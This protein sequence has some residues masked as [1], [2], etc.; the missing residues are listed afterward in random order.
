MVVVFV[1]GGN[2]W[3]EGLLLLLM[4]RWWIEITSNQR[5]QEADRGAKQGV[6]GKKEEKR[7]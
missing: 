3:W 4:M 2:G 5:A 1:V 6:K 7:L